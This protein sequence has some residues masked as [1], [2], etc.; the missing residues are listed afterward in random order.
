MGS[1][2]EITVEVQ[3]SALEGA[4]VNVAVAIK[5]ILDYTIYAVAILDVNGTVLEGGYDTII[6]GATRSWPFSFI[7]PSTNALL[8]TS[9][10]CESYLFDW[11]KD[12][13]VQHT[14]LVTTGG[15]GGDGN[16]GVSAINIS[17][18]MSMM[19]VVMMMSMLSKTMKGV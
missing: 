5:N 10:W 8:T 4:T 18:L 19:M 12:Y 1:Y 7:M 13:S 11:Q 2:T 6:P 9:S 3:G 15:N 16:G 17:D 14:V